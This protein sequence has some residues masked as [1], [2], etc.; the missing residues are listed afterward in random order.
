MSKC[1]KCGN[2]L[3]DWVFCNKC[4]TNVEEYLS[5]IQGAEST[6]QNEIKRCPKCGNEIGDWTFCNKCGTNIETYVVPKPEK[7]FVNSVA[8]GQNFLNQDNSGSNNSH[9]TANQPERANDS[10]V[11]PSFYNSHSRESASNP[12]NVRRD[13]TKPQKKQ[14]KKSKAPIIIV[15]SVIGV[16]SVSVIVLIVALVSSKPQ[17]VDYVSYS[18]NGNV[19]N[20]D[21]VSSNNSNNEANDNNNVKDSPSSIQATEGITAD[22]EYE[23]QKTLE[24]ATY[25]KSASA[26]S[27]LPDQAGHQYS[28]SNVL[29]NDGTCWCEDDSEYGEGEWIKLDLPAVQKLS[30]L[31]IINGYAGTEKQYDYNSKITEVRLEFSNGSSTT[32]SLNVFPTSQRKTVQNIK[33]NQPIETDYVKITIVSV[34]KG[35]CK[36]TCLT[37]V[38]P[39]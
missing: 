6:P 16:L 37:F 36:D 34:S 39:Y 35:E 32:V 31:H 3:G 19:A 15:A 2:E 5:S 1:P 4:G 38:E 21:Y 33:F 24:N 20:D 12:S 22:V 26:S 7:P 29:K 13:N 30:G 17:K 10:V 28:A 14:T 18:D 25:F 8:N 11:P 9:N 23:T 27:V